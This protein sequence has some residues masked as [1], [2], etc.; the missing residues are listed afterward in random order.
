MNGPNG[1]S[2]SSADDG[3]DV[4]HANFDWGSVSPSMAVVETVAIAADR[5]PTD[6]QP[7][8]ETFDPDALDTLV[9]NV[10]AAESDL[11]LAFHVD[12][13]HVTVT[14]D[15]DVFVESNRLRS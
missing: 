15:G 1:S 6:L 10:D 7:L 5:K 2:A 14:G 9:G 3:P 8:I 13:F 11:T 12:E 4:I